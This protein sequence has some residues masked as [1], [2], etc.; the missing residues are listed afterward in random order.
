[1]GFMQWWFPVRGW[2]RSKLRRRGWTSNPPPPPPPPPKKKKNPN[3][4]PVP[5]RRTHTERSYGHHANVGTPVHGNLAEWMVIMM[6]LICDCH[7][8]RVLI[9]AGFDWREPGCSMC[10]AMN[11]DKLLPGERC[12]STSNR[13]FEG[14]QVR[15]GV[16][17]AYS[18]P[19]GVP[20]PA[21]M[22]L[23]SHNHAV[24]SVRIRI[25]DDMN[26]HRAMVGALIS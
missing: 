24:H 4:Q 1:M 14:R 13:N 5:Q 23:P 11:P 3:P 25:N 22:L 21:S 7:L 20:C 6:M 9:A 17:P 10:L 12:A 2:S 16:L 26:F 18:L 19:S 8:S 15:L